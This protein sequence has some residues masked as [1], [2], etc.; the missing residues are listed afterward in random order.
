MLLA[1]PVKFEP[2]DNGTI[3]AELPDVPGTMTIGNTERQALERAHGALVAML[4]AR[5][6]DHEPIP[7][8]S[9]PKKGQPI[10][11]LVPL[12]AAKLAIYEAM[13]RG[14]IT[15]VELAGR[16]GCDGRQVRRLLDLQHNSRLDHLDAAL[17]VLGKQLVIDVRDAA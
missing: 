10:V 17:R 14:N 12:I 7:A 4:A 11:A 1:Y 8:P 15:Q 2:D 9:R 3:I 5:M 16:L 6:E 13:R